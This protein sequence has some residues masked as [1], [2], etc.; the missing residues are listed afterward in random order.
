MAVLLDEVF[1]RNGFW[2]LLTPACYQRDTRLFS[3]CSKLSPTIYSSS[4]CLI[5]AC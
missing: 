1:F 2:Q 5:R 4:F 3:A